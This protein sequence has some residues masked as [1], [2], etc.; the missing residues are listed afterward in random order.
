[1][2]ISKTLYGEKTIVQEPERGITSLKLT[3]EMKHER[4]KNRSFLSG[5]DCWNLLLERKQMIH[6]FGGA[7]LWFGFVVCLFEI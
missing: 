5:D 4:T 2:Y 3:G 6:M 7:L 1:M